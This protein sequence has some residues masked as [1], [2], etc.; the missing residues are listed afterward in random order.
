MFSQ[1]SVTLFRGEGSGYDLDGLTIPLSPGLVWSCLG[2]RGYGPDGLAI[3]PFP[4]LTADCTP[5]P[6][7]KDH[8]RTSGRTCQE[9]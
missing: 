2:G 7:E 8:G 9:R 5:P 4:Q 1:V 3:A 6:Q